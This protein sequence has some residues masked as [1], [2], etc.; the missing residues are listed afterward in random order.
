MT[1]IYWTST[2]YIRQRN[3][4]FYFH[5]GSVSDKADFAMNH[6]RQRSSPRLRQGHNETVYL[7]S[8]AIPAATDALRSCMM[9]PRSLLTLA[10]LPLSLSMRSMRR[11]PP[12]PTLP[13]LTLTPQDADKCRSRIPQR[14]IPHLRRDTLDGLLLQGSGHGRWE[15]FLLS[16]NIRIRSLGYYADEE[17]HCPDQK[18][19]QHDQGHFSDCH[20]KEVRTKVL[21]HSMMIFLRTT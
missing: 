17:A 20:I 9:Y 5:D 6:F 10:T 1:K 18:V 11:S 21:A 3:V 19:L 16:I 14:G 4:K 2:I 13:P 7:D 12:P 15:I 8:Y